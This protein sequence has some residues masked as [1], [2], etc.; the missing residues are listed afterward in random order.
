MV[1]RFTPDAASSPGGASSQAA[2]DSVPDLVVATEHSAENADATGTKPESDTL[3]TS[4]SSVKS[5]LGE[6]ANL[7]KGFLGLNFLYVSYAFSYAGV[8]RG[9]LGL[10][11]VSLLTFYGCVLLVRVKRHIPAEWWQ[12]QRGGTEPGSERAPFAEV[13]SDSPGAASCVPARKVLYGD[14]GAYAFGRA[15][16][17]V[18][19]LA[20]LLTQFGYCTGYLI[21]LAQTIHDLTRCDCAPAWFLLIPLPIVLTLAL[22]RSLRKL[23][24]FSYLA[25]IGIFV[26]FS[27][28]LVFLMANFQYRPYSPLFWK[29]PVF[30]GQMSAALEGIGVVL[31]VEGSMKNPRRFNVILSATMVLMGAILLL[32]GL[33]GFMTFG[34][35]TRSIILLNMGH[36]AA[37]R[38]VKSVACIGILFTYPLQLVPIV[39]ALEAWLATT[40]WLRTRQLGTGSAHSGEP[41]P[42]RHPEPFDETVSIDAIRVVET[43]ITPERKASRAI[44]GE[45]TP[46]PLDE[47]LAS[48][49][50]VDVRVAS[51]QRDS[52]PGSALLFEESGGSKAAISTSPV[53]VPDHID[54]FGAPGGASPPSPQ[55]SAPAEA[56]PEPAPPIAADRAPLAR[57]VAT[58][59]CTYFTD[60][61]AAVL[62][63]VSLVIG[64]VVA[65]V[66]AGK[67]FG[68]FQSLVGAL[69]AATLAYTLPALFHLRVFWQRLSTWERAL[70]IFMLA[71]GAVA[72]L[73]ATTT[74]IAEMVRGTASG[75][76]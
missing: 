31:P 13:S 36:S 44:D 21:F 18:V 71:F 54:A 28:V 15:G 68:L 19:N 76:A 53:P 37:V 40:T 67:D 4:G 45:Q 58:L 35:Q 11:L 8:T 25:N 43:R 47:R 3:R 51:E 64:T 30:F 23:T 33:L 7:L 75:I 42:S 20:L 14:V 46:E 48:I 2:A 39:Q 63:R 62:V 72:T 27:A 24:P 61:P 69:G 52:G 38:I 32:I 73:S 56:P 22:L 10:V 66:I 59:Y 55:A 74:T 5:V 65:A 26:G 57:R 60:E 34:K 17:L 50:I 6:F 9:I 41:L 1:G 16:E 70:D 49:D 12:R 29:W